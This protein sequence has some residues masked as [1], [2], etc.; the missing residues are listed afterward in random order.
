MRPYAGLLGLP[1]VLALLATCEEDQVIGD[2]EPDRV[3]CEGDVALTCRK[4]GLTYDEEDCGREAEICHPGL[5]CSRCHPGGLFCDDQVVVRCLDDGDST[6]AVAECQTADNEVCYLGN[7][8]NACEA[9]N[10]DRSYVGCEYWA[11]DLDNAMIS[12]VFN[13]AA[14]QFAVVVSNV[15]D[16]EATVVVDRNDAPPGWPLELTRVAEQVVPP[17]GLAVIQ[18]D[19]R[20]VDGSPPG[21]YDTG[22]HTALTSNA[23]RVRSSVPIIAYQFSPLDNVQVFSNDASLLVPTSA[24]DTKYRV[25][26]WPQTIAQTNDPATNFHKHLRAFLTIVGVETGTDVEI[27]LS[28]DIVGSETIPAARAGET[29]TASLGPFD[30]LNLETGD[31]AADFTGTEIDADK[32]VAVFSGSEASDVPMFWHLSDRYCC[33]DHLQHQLYPVQSAGNTFVVARMPARTPAVFEAGGDVSIVDEIDYVKVLA[34]EDFTEIVTTLLEPYNHLSLNRGEHA[35]LPTYCDFTLQS[36]RP[37][38]VGQ[39]VAG[40]ATTGISNDLPGGD[41]SFILIP[42][43]EQ[44]RPDYVFLT[45]DKYAFDFV[46][47]V[48]AETNPVLFDYLPMGDECEVARAQCPEYTDIRTQ[49]QVYRCQLGFPLIIPGLAPPDNIDPHDQ[50]DGY[51]VSTAEEPFG[52]IVYGFD[53]HVSYG[54]AGGTY[55]HRIY[56]VD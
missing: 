21:E 5:G 24:L 1:L 27:L 54:Y 17:Q 12:S 25:L 26:G 52:L 44:W 6:E 8:I 4:D 33:A 20:E 46:V 39:F 23:Y 45:P 53:K 19:P 56:D 47:I 34:L 9:A 30:V 51:H 28:T 16:V 42:P 37:V 55:L 10:E 36:S 49:Y 40:Q 22:T 35:I 48:T 38:F 32:P 7:C 18:L 11:V 3:Y 15:S 29:I 43:V 50:N 31:F 13:A 2:C 14:Q 41:P